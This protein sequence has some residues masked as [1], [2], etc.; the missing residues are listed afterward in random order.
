MLSSTKVTHN[1]SHTLKIIPNS[2]KTYITIIEVH[3]KSRN[4][5]RVQG[6]GGEPLTKQL[7]AS[8]YRAQ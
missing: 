1:I 2:H 8:M 3:E 6:W 5:P 4:L 7:Q